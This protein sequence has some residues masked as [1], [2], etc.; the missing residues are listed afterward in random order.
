M[1]FVGD[2]G[3][4]FG[5]FLGGSAISF[6]EVLDLI[7]YNSLVK[8]TPRRV[9]GQPKVLNAGSVD[10]ENVEVARL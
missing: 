6:F 5:L 9:P 7:I 4:Y 2:F 8:F 10:L 1:Y 3:G